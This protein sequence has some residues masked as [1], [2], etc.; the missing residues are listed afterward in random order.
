[1][2][3]TN[4]VTGDAISPQTAAGIA[5]PINGHEYD[6]QRADLQYTCIFPLRT[7]RDCAGPPYPPGCDC[8]DFQ[9]QNKP[10]CEG[11][12]QRYA[13]AYPS[14][15]QLALLSRLGAAG[16]AASICP[17]NFEDASRPDYAYAPAVQAII[18]RLRVILK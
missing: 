16:V 12:L 17:R 18:E 6:T 13:K 9:A 7:P 1:R 8:F 4:P 11:T 3:G 10:L 5:N 14:N 15:R 2:S